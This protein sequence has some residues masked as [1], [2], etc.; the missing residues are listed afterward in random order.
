MKDRDSILPEIIPVN[1]SSSCHI[2]V[3]ILLVH[4]H[5]LVQGKT[6]L[7]MFVYVHLRGAGSHFSAP[8]H[9]RDADP[10]CQ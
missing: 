7:H 2:A 6:V 5:A 1:L 3:G 8:A 10:Q 9:L 4:A